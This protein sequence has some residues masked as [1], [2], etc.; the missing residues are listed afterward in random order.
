M[1]SIFKS[2]LKTMA[3][4]ADNVTRALGLK[5]FHGASVSKRS[6]WLLSLCF[7]FHLLTGF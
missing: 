4:I 5:G 2:L 6:C 7:I 3:K 1:D